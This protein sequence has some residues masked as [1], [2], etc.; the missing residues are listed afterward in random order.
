MTAT[1]TQLP[2]VKEEAA[3]T[4]K[5]LFRKQLLP[6]GEVEHPTHGKLSFDLAGLVAR[7]KAGAMDQ[8]PF[9]IAGDDRDHPKSGGDPERFRGE[10][11]GLELASDGLY[12]TIETTERGAELLAE[13]PNLPVSVRVKVPEG[14]RFAGKE[15]LAHVVGTMDPVAT[16]MR[17]WEAVDASDGVEVTDLSDGG[18]YSPA[19]ST[20]ADTTAKDGLD[21]SDEEKGV[22]RKILD[23]V[24]GD[25]KPDESKKTDDEP[26]DEEVQKAVEQLLADASDDEADEEKEG[27]EEKEPVAA[28]LSD[29]DRKTLEM[30][31]E[32][33][34]RFELKAGK[35]ELESKLSGYVKD[36]VP[37]AMVEAARDLLS[38]DETLIE[39]ANDRTPGPVTKTFEALDKA[40]G[41]IE[42]SERGS[43]AGDDTEDE[44]AAKERR[45]IAEEAAK[46]WT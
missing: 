40:K 23:R 27:D 21:F 35:S 9:L 38:G 5:R 8:V 20:D 6:S 29:E 31:A 17:P 33:T 42:F 37:P 18:A 32:K 26:S 22:L 11:K 13:N 14:G 1:A 28:S 39:L 19:I 24:K 3:R 46:G 16:G 36:G 30:A 7:F 41:T 12:G 15:V 34:K 10:I 2:F 25:D 43:S 4:G 44:E 45:E